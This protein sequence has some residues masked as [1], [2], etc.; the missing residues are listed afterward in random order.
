MF[1][2]VKD[3]FLTFLVILVKIVKAL[4]VLYVRHDVAKLHAE[5]VDQLQLF[6]QD[7]AFFHLIVLQKDFYLFN[8][9]NGHS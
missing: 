4:K 6:L 2:T 1:S 3:Y 8:L 7:R 5:C 9:R